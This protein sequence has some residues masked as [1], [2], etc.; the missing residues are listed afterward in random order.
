[1]VKVGVSQYPFVHKLS[2]RYCMHFVTLTMT[3]APLD[4]EKVFQIFGG[5]Q[6]EE[7][8]RCATTAA[9]ATTWNNC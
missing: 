8:V 2:V 1:M 3:V 7:V 4:V 5:R 6:D 9:E